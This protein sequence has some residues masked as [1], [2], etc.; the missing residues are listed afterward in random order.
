MQAEAQ[1]R[2]RSRERFGV[3]KHGAGGV[4]SVAARAKSREAAQAKVGE[5][6]LSEM[7]GMG[8]GGS[9]VNIHAANNGERDRREK[10]KREGGH[11]AAKHAVGGAG[12]ARWALPDIEAKSSP[13][14]AAAKGGSNGGGLKAGHLHD[15]G[16]PG[17]IRRYAGQTRY[18]LPPSSR[19]GLA[20]RPPPHS[21]ST[22]TFAIRA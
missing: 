13:W 2:A 20:S 3:V 7:L 4:G 14:L 10:E 19:E 12:R 9:S 17:L 5:L 22:N 15:F 18:V 6:S 16:S 1:G 21:L 11:G 8:G